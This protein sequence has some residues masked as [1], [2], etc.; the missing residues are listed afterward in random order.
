MNLAERNFINESL[1]SDYKYYIS[2]HYGGELSKDF[3]RILANGKEL[4]LY[5]NK[6]IIKLDFKKQT[7]K[8]TKLINADAS[9]KHYFLKQ[10]NNLIIYL[11]LTR[12]I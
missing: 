11:K 5:Y 1:Q 9:A 7:R 2:E 4:N 3:L 10:I 8:L 6:K 12:E